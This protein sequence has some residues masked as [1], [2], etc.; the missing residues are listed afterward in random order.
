MLKIN[1]LI[2]CLLLVVTTG[3][4][5]QTPAPPQTQA[6]AIM[7]ATAHLGNGQ[8]IQNSIIAFE[9]GKLS[10]VGDAEIV[11]IDAKKY[12]IIDAAG[13]H[14]FPGFIATT[15]RMGLV[16]I[17]AV[18][19][20]RDFREV[21]LMNPNVRAIIAYNTDSRVTPTIRSNGVLMAQ[22]IPSG[23]RIP[24]SSSVVQLD[25]W[26]WEDAAYATDNGIHLNWPSMFEFSGWW[27]EPGEVKK[28]K[29]YAEQ[30]QRIGD[31]FDEAKAYAKG[32][33]NKEKNLKME[34]MRGLFDQSKTL[35]V[36]TNSAKTITEAVL[37]AKKHKVKV[38]ITGARDSWMVADLLKKENVAVI[39]RDVHS[40]PGREDS[41]I[42][43][44]FKTAVQLQDAGVLF[45][46]GMNGAWQQR[47]LPFQAGHAVGFGLDY[48][49]AVSGL[50]LNTAK[51]L[52]IDKTTG[53]LEQGKDATLF[54]SVGD[55]LDMRT[56]KLEQAFIQGREIDLDNK[57]KALNRK[58]KA[59]LGQE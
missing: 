25:A 54:I 44:P 4:A 30:V 15:S 18:R 11:R 22:I 58:F 57:Q 28:N 27:A 31:F 37:F 59:K 9:N 32:N 52:G 10:L 33:K 2:A 51:I 12:K 34:A 26:N 20:T 16:E 45:A 43:Q 42:D 49:A 35:Y 6:I 3:L 5:Q 41:D 40:L 8:V 19:S 47:N 55:A 46:F 29:K 53:S 13:K 1:I 24:G 21:G 17:E 48:E 36:N 39:L 7:G 23:G 50:T 14:V 56:C 38:V